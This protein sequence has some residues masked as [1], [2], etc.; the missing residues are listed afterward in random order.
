MGVGLP[1][2]AKRR[3]GWGAAGQKAHPHHLQELRLQQ[4]PVRSAAQ[5]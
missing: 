5:H 3:G 2:G 1:G 4:Q